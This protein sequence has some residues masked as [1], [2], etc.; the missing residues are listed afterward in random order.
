MSEDTKRWVVTQNG[1]A[2]CVGLSRSQAENKVD[3]ER[4]ND[5]YME[6]RPALDSELNPPVWC[7]PDGDD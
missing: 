2:V 6:A 5:N 1:M 4:R 7:D 3:N